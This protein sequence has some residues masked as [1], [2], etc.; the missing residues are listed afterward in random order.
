MFMLDTI[1]KWLLKTKKFNFNEKS[2]IWQFITLAK[3]EL[4]METYQIFL[5]THHLTLAIPL[6]LAFL[7]AIPLNLAF[8][9]AIPLTLAFLQ[10]TNL[11]DQ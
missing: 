4:H 2:Q 7:L 8:L 3:F 5:Y 9:L 11:P 1:A 6:T 10:K